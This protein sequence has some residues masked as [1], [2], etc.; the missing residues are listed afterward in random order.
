M[1]VYRMITPYCTKFDRLTNRK[2]MEIVATRGQILM[3]KC[4]K[5]DFGPP[6]RLWRLDPRA[7]G[8]R[9]GACGA[10]TPR[11]HAFGVRLPHRG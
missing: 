5:I 1:F 10:S 4:T 2:F 7:F 3:A 8:A 11:S 6:R 9:L